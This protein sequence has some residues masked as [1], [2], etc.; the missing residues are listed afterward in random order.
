MQPRVI[1]LDVGWTL[2]FPIRSIWEIF[3]DLCTEGGVPTTAQACE[4]NIRAL[5]SMAQARAAEEFHP[6]ARYSD[7]DA[8]FAAQFDLLGRVIFPS[9]GLENDLEARMA[10]FLERFWNLENW[11]IFPDVLPTLEEFRRRGLRVGILSNAPTDMPQL[12][13]RLGI[14]PWLDYQVVSA[15][16]G[17]RKPDRRLFSVAVERAGVDPEAILHVGDMYVEDIVGG[18][19]A[20]LSTLLMERGERALFP[21]FRESEGRSLDADRIVGSLGDVLARLG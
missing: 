5:W 2:A 9:L 19:A 3:A 13:D 16:E 4:E 8:E 21:S 12:L 11:Q 7:S 15:A 17:C 10:S 20:G 6:E 1:S 14:S 18:S